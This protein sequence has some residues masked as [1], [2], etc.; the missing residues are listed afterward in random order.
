VKIRNIKALAPFKGY[1]VTRINLKETGAQIN[2][3]FD[4][5]SGPGRP[6]CVQQLPRNK[7]GRRAVMDWD[8]PWRE[9][10]SGR[11]AR[12]RI[13]GNPPQDVTIG[14]MGVSVTNPQP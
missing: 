2:L 3:D 10:S 6:H 5:L 13:A 8:G 9:S 11:G 14:L 4:K 12:G 1:V 7:A